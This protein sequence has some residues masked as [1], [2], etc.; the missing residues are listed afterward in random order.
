MSSAVSSVLFNSNEQAFCHNAI[1][2]AFTFYRNVTVI[3]SYCVPAAFAPRASEPA[4]RQPPTLSDVEMSG[5]ETITRHE[6]EAESER[7]CHTLHTPT[8]ILFP[9]AKCRI[10]S[11]EKGNGP[12]LAAHPQRPTEQ[13]KL[14][15]VLFQASLPTRFAQD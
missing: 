14:V 15:A 13:T 6:Q 2:P 8:Y 5:R 9:P 3:L 12:A 1:K 4:E 11:P 7:E 10:L